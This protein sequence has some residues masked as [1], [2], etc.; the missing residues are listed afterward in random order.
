[1]GNFLICSGEL[2]SEEDDE[3]VKKGILDGGI[4][5]QKGGTVSTK[6]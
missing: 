3:I 5:N 4:L 1:M 2:R 6:D